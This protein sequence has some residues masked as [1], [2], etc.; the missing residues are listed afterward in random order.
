MA[1]LS[2]EELR[3]EV[4]VAVSETIRREIA[5]LPGKL[6]EKICT[7]EGISQEDF[8]RFSVEQKLA[9]LR[10]VV[11]GNGNFWKDYSG[12]FRRSLIALIEAQEL[13]LRG[14]ESKSLLRDIL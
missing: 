2:L 6:F 4:E 1:T 9:F 12:D 14:S 11:F 8:P 13:V 3:R 7:S 5:A 10:R